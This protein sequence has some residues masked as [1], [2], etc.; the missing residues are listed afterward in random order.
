VRHGVAAQTKQ[1]VNDR[2]RIE[3]IGG[4]SREELPPGAHRT[5]AVFLGDLKGVAVCGC[6]PCGIAHGEDVAA[7]A[8]RAGVHPMAGGLLSQFAS[9][10]DRG[11]RVVVDARCTRNSASSCVNFAVRACR[12]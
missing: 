2:Y 9:F 1:P 7:K 10:R 3:G 5:C 11:E 12:L 6:G 8:M 4:A